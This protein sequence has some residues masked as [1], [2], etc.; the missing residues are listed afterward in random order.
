MRKNTVTCRPHFFVVLMFALILGS[1]LASNLMAAEK[2]I[3]ASQTHYFDTDRGIW[4]VDTDGDGIVDLTEELEGTDP[5]DSESFNGPKDREDAIADKAGFPTAS[6]R[7][8]FR[9]V[10]SRLC[11]SPDEENA[12]R[13]YDAA[14]FCRDKRSKVCTYEDMYYLYQR[15]T[16][17]G[18]YNPNGLFLGGM[19][20]DDRLLCGNKSITFNGDPDRV[21][22]EGDCVK[23]ASRQFY[24]CHDRE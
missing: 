20:K 10:G 4:L 18:S 12:R 9:A 1:G 8:G 15:S 6:C 24:C 17:D 19:Q 11:I 7:T 2:K 16:L 23:T 14:V 5:F 3:E 13:S 21:N 22:F